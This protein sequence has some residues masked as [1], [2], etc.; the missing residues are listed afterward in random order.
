MCE[1]NKRNTESK[2]VSR[3]MKGIEFR[4]GNFQKMAPV[5]II[6]SKLLTE[7]FIKKCE[8]EFS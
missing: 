6:P 1:I 2:A 8:C 5:E 3:N 4:V 7:R